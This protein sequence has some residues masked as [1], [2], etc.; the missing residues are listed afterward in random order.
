MQCR[1]IIALKKIKLE[2]GSLA[3]FCSSK[4]GKNETSPIKN[5]RDK[6]VNKQRVIESWNTLIKRA[7]W[8]ERGLSIAGLG[9]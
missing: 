1:E 4:P 2:A 7:L 3:K 5:S 8:D 9:N 6:E